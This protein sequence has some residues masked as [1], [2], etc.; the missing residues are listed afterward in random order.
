MIRL[1]HRRQRWLRGFRSRMRRASRP[2][3]RFTPAGIRGGRFTPLQ[4]RTDPAADSG[5]EF[6][7]QLFF[8]DTLTDE[9]FSRAVCQQCQRNTRNDDDG[10]YRN[11]AIT[12]L[13]L[14]EQD[15][16]YARRSTS[17]ST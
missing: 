11:A 1:Q 6:T 13:K 4:F 5:Y 9:V 15:D 14:V 16:G 8:D 10:I 3:R 17:R 2:S 12:V 7:S